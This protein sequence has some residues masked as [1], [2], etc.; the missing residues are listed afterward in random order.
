MTGKMALPDSSVVRALES[1]IDEYCRVKVVYEKAN[2]GNKEYILEPLKIAFFD[3]FWYLIAQNKTGNDVIK[4]RLER[5]KKVDLLDTTFVPTPQ[6]DKLLSESVNIWFGSKRG[7]RVLI[8]IC[9]SVV[10]YF[11]E[12]AYFPLQKIVEERKDGSI[13]VETYP[14]H[15]DEIIHIIMN[16]IPCLKVLEPLAFKEEVKRTVA[17]YLQSL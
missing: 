5:I 17:S 7:E 3:G 9:P 13:V 14:A 12:K 16:W 2:E 10:R 15:P 8:G 6:I 1:A 11:K 4:F